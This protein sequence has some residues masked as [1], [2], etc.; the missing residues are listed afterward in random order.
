MEASAHTD[1]AHNGRNNGSAV[2]HG[3]FKLGDF[4]HGVE[5]KQI[6]RFAAKPSKR[7][8]SFDG[9]FN[10]RVKHAYR[11]REAMRVSHALCLYTPPSEFFLTAD[12]VGRI[13][14]TS[15]NKSYE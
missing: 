4:K 8:D 15:P 11:T 14:R 1:D 12:R 10:E 2:E 6:A 5:F 7:T 9:E 13:T 3:R